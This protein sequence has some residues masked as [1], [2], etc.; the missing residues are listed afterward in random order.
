ME[1][2]KLADTIGTDRLLG[3]SVNSRISRHRLASHY[4]VAETQHPL[5]L[6]VHV[7]VH[8]HVCSM[9]WPLACPVLC[10][11]PVLCNVAPG[12][13]PAPPCGTR[14]SGPL[15][16]CNRARA[17]PTSPSTVGEHPHSI[18]DHALPYGNGNTSAAFRVRAA[19]GIVHTLGVS[20]RPFGWASGRSLDCR[21]DAAM[22]CDGDDAREHA[23]GGS[24][25]HVPY[26]MVAESDAVSVGFRNYWR[27]HRPYRRGAHAGITCWRVNHGRR[28][29]FCCCCC[30]GASGCG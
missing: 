27:A 29:R 19:M 13:T 26:Y 1:H 12:L 9:V 14:V 2:S 30:N 3:H 25:I 16:H 28:F 11:C 22:F 8:V 7:H 5:P 18:F 17:L 15:V 10:C 20:E 23:L 24:S 6:H 4:V 21:I